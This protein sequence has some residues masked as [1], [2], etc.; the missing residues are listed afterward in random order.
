MTTISKLSTMFHGRKTQDGAGVKLTRIFGT[1]DPSIT[2]PF[3]LFDYFGSN[4]PADYM[5]GF[6]W[7]PHR[8]IET[9]TYMLHGSVEHSDSMGNSGVIN[10]GDIQ[11]MTAGSGIIHQEMPLEQ[12]DFMYGFQL[13]VNLPAKR[14]M[15]DPRYRG[16]TAK[17]IP[18]V[19]TDNATIKLIS[20]TV[21]NTV[22]PVT[23]LVVD[24]DYLDVKVEK[25][26]EFS[27]DLKNG[28]KALVYVFEGSGG[29]SDSQEIVNGGSCLAFDMQSTQIKVKTQDVS[30]R[31]M[32]ISGIPL[33]EP[34]S[35]CGPIV[36]NT[37]EECDKAFQE[38]QNNT[39]VKVKKPLGI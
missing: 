24:V 9:I 27:Y 39:F 10:T 17:D 35:W 29:F 5:D 30:V 18:I 26:S 20:G 1:S 7:H 16:F 4:N 37:E 14:K 13:W 28:H 8:G 34:I 3:L 21:G 31:F 33:N 2:D 36:M 38:Y 15:T 12:K 19:T 22:G 23:D 32:L 11:W 25:Q 6:P